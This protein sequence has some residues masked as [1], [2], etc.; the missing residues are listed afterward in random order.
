L[1]RAVDRL[2]EEGVMPDD[3]FAQI[4]DSLYQPHHFKAVAFLEKEAFDDCFR[5]ASAVISHA[6]MGA[7]AMALDQGKPLL[8]MP[9]QREYQEVVNSHQTDL[10]HRFEAL[11]HILVAQNETQL[12]AKVEQLRSFVPRPRQANP[13]VVAARIRRFLEV[14]DRNGAAP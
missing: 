12:R 9:R 7:I 5:R 13:E 6:G 14:R 4:G 1:V 8:V 2:F 3:L 10:A 11:G